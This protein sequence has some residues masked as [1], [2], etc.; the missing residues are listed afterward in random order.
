VETNP[1]T[2]IR[3]AAGLLGWEEA[4][5]AG[6]VR[7]SGVRADLAAWLPLLPAVGPGPP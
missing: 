7:A 6:L 3:L 5:A 2:W 4:R 1:V